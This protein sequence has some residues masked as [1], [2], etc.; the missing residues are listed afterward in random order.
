MGLD[1]CVSL[2]DG[3][4]SC[5]RSFANPR[6]TEID[7]GLNSADARHTER[8]PDRDRD[9]VSFWGSQLIVQV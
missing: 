7:T 3:A 4:F 5:S 9:I 2:H 8:R 1:F 6:G